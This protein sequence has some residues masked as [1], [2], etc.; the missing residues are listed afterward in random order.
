M[1]RKDHRTE[2]RRGQDGGWG[3]IKEWMDRTWQK[4]ARCD[5]DCGFNPRGK[6]PAARL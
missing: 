5:E 3:C 1:K 2:K 4:M 6:D